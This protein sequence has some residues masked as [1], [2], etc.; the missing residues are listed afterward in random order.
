MGS[1]RPF[2]RSKPL[3]RDTYATLPGGVEKENAACEIRKPLYGMSTERKDRYGGIRDFLAKECG[4]EGASLDKSVLFWT[5]QG[6]GYGYGREISRPRY[7][8]S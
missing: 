1:P 3:K 8:K 6:L 2:S 4:R 5:Q 7:N